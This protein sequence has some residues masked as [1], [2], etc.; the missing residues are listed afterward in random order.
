MAAR[1]VPA[2]LAQL[3]NALTVFRFA[4][5]PVFAVLAHRARTRREAGPRRASSRSPAITD[6]IDGWLARRWH[7]ESRFGKFADPLADRL[8]IDVAIL[9]LW[10]DGRL[11]WAALVVILVRDGALI[12]GYP[13]VRNRGYEFEVNFLGKLATWVLYASLVFV[14][15]TSDGTD[16]PLV[17]F[18]I[19]VGARA[20]RGRAVPPQGRPGDPVKAVVMAGGEGTRLR[21]LTSNQPK[22]MVPIVGKPCME[23]VIDL[24]R[25]HGFDD[26]VVTLA[27]MPQ[28]IRSYFGDGSAHGVRIRYSVEETPAGTAGS[29]KLAE[30]ALDEPFLV[31]SGDALCDIDL[32]RA[33]PHPRGA[34][35][36][37][38]DRA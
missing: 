35:V 32:A 6:Q 15:G 27:F 5:I 7:V 33:R 18:W 10:L 9:L 23:H 29:V 24:L 12:V 4:L 19:G 25:R 28:A 13:L 26:I 22:P 38:H 3:P 20:R 1:A 14:T 36:A 8:M 34:R 21:P 2:P 30:E 16:W 31:I 11:P 37:R 17:L